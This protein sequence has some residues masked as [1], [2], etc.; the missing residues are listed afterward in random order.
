MIRKSLLFIFSCLLSL[1][2]ALADWYGDKY[3]MFIHYGLYSIPAGVFDGEPVRRGYSEQILTFGIGFSDW[4]EAYRH[5]FTAERFD[6]RAIVDLA[7][8]SGMRSVVITAKHHDGFCLFDTATTEYNSVKGAPA[9]RDLVG[10]LANACHEAGI[11]FGIYFSL[12]DWHYPY[13]VPFSSHNADRVTHPHHELNKAQVRELLTHYGR[14]DEL[15]FDMGSLSTAQSSELYHLVHEIQPD[16][17]VSGRLGNDYADFAVMPDNALPDYS[18]AMPWQTAASIFPET[19]GYRSWQERSEVEPKV[20]EKFTD[21]IHVVTGGGKYLL[22]IGPMGDGSVVPFEQEVLTR[23]GALIAPISEAIYDTHPTPVGKLMTLSADESSLYIFLPRET[24]V[25]TTP[26]LLNKPLSA[27]LLGQNKELPF[28]EHDGQV[29]MNAIPTTEVWNVVKLDFS[30]P[31]RFDY[32]PLA[33]TEPLLN[34]HNAIPLYAHSSVDYYA[35]YRS[36]VGY[37]WYIPRTGKYRIYFTETEKHKTIAL[38]DTLI[39]L[40]PTGREEVECDWQK[41]RTSSPLRRSLARGLFGNMSESR[42]VFAE[43][44]GEWH[45]RLTDSI[46]Q[47]SGVVYAQTFE[48]DTDLLLAIRLD[49]SDGVLVY[50]NGEY[51]DGAFRRE[52]DGTLHLLLPFIKGSNELIVKSYNH[53][54]DVA[55]LQIH[56]LAQYTRYSYDFEL[57]ATAPDEIHCIE[58]KHPSSALPAQPA[59]LS[60][61]SLHTLTGQQ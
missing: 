32:R 51:I 10:E 14:V 25:F 26:K 54:G 24:K 56:P 29:T 37:R 47:R 49:Y 44:S 36:I 61:I 18:M 7:K 16:C 40:E 34:A 31:V 33:T 35:T 58:L 42:R 1:G 55:V 45:S 23:M 9:K 22:N 5:D 52:G 57:S 15:W 50:L 21:L 60:S 53:L 39:T 19:W 12:I 38:N 20:E 3:S 43:V 46:P 8:A 59:H 4:Y 13:A 41:V 48:A 6:A 2:I 30:E 17:M 28:S 11:G 27:T